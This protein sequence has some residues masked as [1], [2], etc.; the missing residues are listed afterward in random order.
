MVAAGQRLVMQTPGGGGLGP[1]QD[2]NEQRIAQDLRAGL[3][4]EQAALKV[5]GY[6][7]AKPKEPKGQ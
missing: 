5:Y 7:R 4:S 3:V 6:P 2:R 1:P